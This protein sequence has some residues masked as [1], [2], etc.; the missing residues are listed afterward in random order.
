M[1]DPLP[2]LLSMM[3]KQYR[4]IWRVKEMVS[5]KQEATEIAK[6]LRMS[7]WNVR[8]LMDQGKHFSVSS[9]REGILRCHQTDLLIK[10]GRV[11]KDLLMEK[12]VIDLC[13]PR[14]PQSL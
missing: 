13:R 4:S 5:Q 7:P 11:E 9:L 10:R 6:A 1:D 12:L 14:N 2:L 3:A 8:K